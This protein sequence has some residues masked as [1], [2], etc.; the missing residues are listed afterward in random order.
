MTIDPGVDDE[1][2][3][4]N[5]HPGQEFNY[6]LDGTLEVT[7]D[8][9]TPVLHEGDSLFFDASLNHG[10]KALGGKQAVFLAVIV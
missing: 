7:I 9:H 5:F 3:S 10:M 1:S 4:L 2:V 6:V 8:N